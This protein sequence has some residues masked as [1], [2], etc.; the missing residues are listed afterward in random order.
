MRVIHKYATVHSS[1]YL[2]I[3][4]TNR[5]FMQCDD[6]DNKNLPAIGG[7]IMLAIPCTNKTIPNAPG[8]FSTP[9][10]SHIINDC[11]IG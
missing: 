2:T 7:P 1:M 4:N 10:R 6:C 5:K 8:S 3:D 9:S 11:S